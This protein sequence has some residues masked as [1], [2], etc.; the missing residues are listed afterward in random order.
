[1]RK[2]TILGL[3]LLAAVLA[4]LSWVTVAEFFDNRVYRI[5][6]LEKIVPVRVL[7]SIPA[8]VRLMPAGLARRKAKMSHVYGFSQ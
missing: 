8:G 5:E 7:A 6:E 2:T 3:A 4:A 1:M